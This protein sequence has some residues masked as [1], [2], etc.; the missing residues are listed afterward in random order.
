VC[1]SDSGPGIAAGL[2]V[3]KESIVGETVLGTD[4]IGGTEDRATSERRCGGR[5]KLWEAVAEAG[6]VLEAVAMCESVKVWET[7]VER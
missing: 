6:R 1:W 2:V 5:R 3:V 4:V 7:V